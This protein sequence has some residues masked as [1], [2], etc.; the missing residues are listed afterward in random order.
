MGLM[1]GAGSLTKPVSQKLHPSWPALCPLPALASRLSCP[2][3][4][5]SNSMSS[6]VPALPAEPAWDGEMN[7]PPHRADSGLG[8]NGPKQ[9]SPPRGRLGSGCL[10]D[11]AKEGQLGGVLLL[12]CCVPQL[13]WASTSANEWQPSSPSNSGRAPHACVRVH[14]YLQSLLCSR[15]WLM[16]CQCGWAGK[17][18]LS[19]TKATQPLQRTHKPHRCRHLDAGNSDPLP[20]IGFP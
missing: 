3:V 14:A 4:A 17:T 11:K 10:L 20:G 1:T 13:W 19:A 7:P 18:S 6:L 16:P 2:P 12:C 9:E 8:A 15:A 5:G